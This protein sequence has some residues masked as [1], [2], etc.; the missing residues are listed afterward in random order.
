MQKALGFLH[1]PL[2][3]AGPVALCCKLPAAELRGTVVLLLL[4]CGERWPGCFRLSY[5]YKGVGAYPP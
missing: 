2:C 1:P 5:I 3:F 4:D